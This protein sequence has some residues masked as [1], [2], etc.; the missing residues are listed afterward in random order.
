MQADSHSAETAAGDDRPV[1]LIVSH[2][3]PSDPDPAEDEISALAV[4]VAA[5]LPDWSIRSATLASKGALARALSGATRVRVYP[6]FMAE[7]WFTT[8]HLPERLA[9]AGAPEV[10]ALAP[11]GTDPAVQ[12]L[13]VDLAREAA[14]AEGR[15]PAG[16]DLL[17]A[18]HGSFRSDGPAAVARQV[19]TM[20]AAQ[21]PFRRVATAFIDHE[22]QIATVAAG[23]APGALCLPFFAARGG[24]VTDDLPEA[25]AQAQFKGR[26]LDPI[27]TDPRVPGL[28]AA[29]LQATL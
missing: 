13:V 23:L 9:Q 22:P 10:I 29:A 20:I 17:L 1:A 21:V 27:G 5:H 25:L 2:G 11:F 24:H 12:Q 6:L 16:V 7:G 15:D 4:K 19:A 8:T 18:A 14:A 28:I 26:L 3:Q